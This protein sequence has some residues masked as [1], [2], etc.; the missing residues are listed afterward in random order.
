MKKA[1]KFKDALD[2]MKFQKPELTVSEGILNECDSSIDY[3][4]GNPISFYTDKVKLQLAVLHRT[5]RKIASNLGCVK[6][7]YTDKVSKQDYFVQPNFELHQF[8]FSKSTAELL[9]N[10][11]DSYKKICCLCTPRLA[12]EWWHDRQR[13]VTVLDIDDR[14]N[15]MPGYQYF[16]LKNPVELKMEFD[17]VIADPP[18]ALLVDEL[19]KSLYSVTAHSPEATICI[20][21]PI[22]K[23]ER[24]FAAF[25]DLQLQRVSFPNLRWNNL[26]NV[27][28]HLFGFYSNR[29]I[30]IK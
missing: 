5:L 1:L 28:N 3:F 7:H 12:H 9:V 22:A 16:D 10:H 15:Y 2:T 25:K 27:Y 4:K 11:F 13:I 18:F 19:R 21:F 24:L 20:I 30:S 14:F 23:E 6:L 26:K 17:L 29:D 8:F